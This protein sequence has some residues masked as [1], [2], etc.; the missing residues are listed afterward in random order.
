MALPRSWHRTF[1]LTVLL[2]G[3]A[4]AGCYPGVAWLP[5]STGFVYTGGKKGKQLLLFDVAAKKSR[6]LAADVGGPCWPAV[7]RDGKQIA[8]ARSV[9]GRSSHLLT[10]VVFDRAGKVVHESKVLK[11]GKGGEGSQVVA[12]A[13]SPAGDKLLA[14]DLLIRTAFYDIKTGTLTPLAGT[15]LIFG[16]SPVR[17]DGKAFVLLRETSLRLVSWDG[18]EQAIEAPLSPLKGAGSDAERNQLKALLTLP[19]LFESGWEGPVA[20]AAWWRFAFRIDTG[21]RSAMEEKRKSPLTADGKLVRQSYSFR[22]G[23]TVRVV[24]LKEP[25]A[26]GEVLGRPLRVEMVRGK[27]APEVI[28]E[29]GMLIKLFPS[30]DGKLLAVRCPRSGA[31]GGKTNDLLVVLDAAGK[32]VARFTAVE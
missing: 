23:V 15:P 10:V 11:W 32:V 9:A 13:W 21:K 27:G 29:K 31:G 2:A 14:S 19:F 25:G 17:P 18:K 30:P 12:L 3:L 24:E 20:R 7:S 28:F 16:D 8:V 5:D 4:S 22:G 1:A 6:V 26:G